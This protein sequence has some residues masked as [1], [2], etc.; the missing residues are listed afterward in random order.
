M[1]LKLSVLDLAPVFEGQ[2]TTDTFRN[3]YELVQAVEEFGYMRYWVAEHHNMEGV[4]SSATAVFIGYLASATTKIRVGAGG[5]ML[6]NHA[7]LIIAEQ[8]GTLASMYPDRIDLGLGRAPGTDQITARALR[9]DERGAYEFDTLVDE[10]LGFFEEHNQPVIAV[11]GKGINVPI[12]LL[13]SSLYS[14]KLAGELG[15]PY[16]FASHFAPDYL[17][18]AIQMYYHHFTPSKWLENPYVIAS[19]NA[20][21]GET[22]EEGEY[23]AS[24]LFQQFLNMVRGKKGKIPLPRNMADVWNEYEKQAV[25]QM[26]KYTFYGNKDTVKNKIEQFL[27]D[28]KID[29][30]MVNSPIYNIKDRI[31]SFKRLAA[32]NE[33]KH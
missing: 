29:E 26:L 16:A 27:Q 19:I 7:P 28:R 25:M 12:W 14:A 17:D 32:M 11:P 20:F 33:N 2:T 10:L 30:I 3:S 13:G 5:I 8:F 31:L 4:A 23:L 15:L 22:D 21:V 6:P 24:S 9:R 18:H 1:S